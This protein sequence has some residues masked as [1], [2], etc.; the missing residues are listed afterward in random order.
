[1]KQAI[2]DS[3]DKVP[4]ADR[5]DY[6]L[7]TTPGSPNFNKY[8]LDLD[9]AHPV[10][11]KNTELLAEKTTRDSVQQQAIQ[12]ALQP[13]E[14][15]INNLKSQ[16]SA[17]QSQSVLPAGHVAVPTDDAQLLQNVK[18]LGNFEEIK[19]KVEEYGPL[20][21]KEE[22]SKR[23]ERFDAAAEAHG[24][25]KAA[26][27]KIAETEKLYDKLE[28]RDIP[29]PK[30]PTENVTHYFVKTKD[31]AGAEKPVVLSEFVKS[32]DNFKP[33]LSSLY[34]VQSQRRRVPNMDVGDSV[35]E[36]SAGD[37]YI[38]RTYVR[39]DKKETN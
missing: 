19:T 24:L 4:E 20:K 8:I 9:P 14:T 30:K 16:L 11:V 7:V 1:M 33:F 13:K 2:F 6:I 27:A 29:D 36:T 18:T 26:F 32:D 10:A 12:A 37:S 39:P 28:P 23:K 17:A 35:E 15:E 34:P 25:D 38:S 22:A 31:A 3:L 21:E 5:G